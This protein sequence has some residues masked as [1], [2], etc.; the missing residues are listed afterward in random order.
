MLLDGWWRGSSLSRGDQVWN[1]AA[2]E[3]CTLSTAELVVQA[4]GFK[5]EVEGDYSLAKCG[6]E[7]CG[8][9]KK[10]GAAYATFVRV[11]SY[12]LHEVRPPSRRRQPRESDGPGLSL[13]ASYGALL[14]I[15]NR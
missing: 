6:Q 15:E 12:S 2:H 1:G 4:R 8:V 14:R 3:V 9:G 5:I 10:K 7:P 11:E 13:H